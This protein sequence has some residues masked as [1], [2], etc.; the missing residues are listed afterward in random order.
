MSREPKDE[1]YNAERDETEDKTKKEKG[2]CSV[3]EQASSSH[4]DFS[5]VN[6]IQRPDLAGESGA[7]DVVDE[8]CAPMRRQP[9]SPKA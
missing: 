2:R 1:N 3:N 6:K 5:S 8:S 4:R 7:G 9:Q